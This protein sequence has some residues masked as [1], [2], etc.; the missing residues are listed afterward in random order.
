MLSNLGNAGFE[1]TLSIE[2]WIFPWCCNKVLPM[3][4][5]QTIYG[6]RPANPLTP[7]PTNPTGTTVHDTKDGRL[8]SGR[9]TK[10]L[11]MEFLLPVA[12]W[13]DETNQK[14]KRFRHR[15]GTD[16][17][18]STLHS[19]RNRNPL[20]AHPQRYRANLPYGPKHSYGGYGQYR[21]LERRIP[22]VPTPT[23]RAQRRGNQR[24]PFPENIYSRFPNSTI[25]LRHGFG[26]KKT[27]CEQIS[28]S[29]SVRKVIGTRDNKQISNT[30][31]KAAPESI[32]I[33]RP[34]MKTKYITW[35]W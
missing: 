3:P 2:Q 1:G 13:I 31:S 23:R 19:T 28:F 8:Q 26:G 22:K 11:S 33:I 34:A 21:A 17:T 10:F 18:G 24:F 4:D 30:L 12:F 20:Y 5:G 35:R 6:C 16:G 27:E 14:S 7:A 15:T 25:S 29:H 32:R 9:D